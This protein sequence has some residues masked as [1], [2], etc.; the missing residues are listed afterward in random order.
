MLSHISLSIFDT[1]TLHFFFL[2]NQI[3]NNY[4][5]SI[6]NINWGPVELQNY[7]EMGEYLMWWYTRHLVMTVICWIWKPHFLYKMRQLTMASGLTQ[8]KCGIR[9]GDMGKWRQPV[10]Y[11]PWVHLGLQIAFRSTNMPIDVL[12]TNTWQVQISIWT[13]L[14]VEVARVIM[15]NM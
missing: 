9:K 13:N 6:A 10:W 11:W 1:L 3:E 14:I 4:T 7:K 2:H 15:S 5:E 12:T 8:P